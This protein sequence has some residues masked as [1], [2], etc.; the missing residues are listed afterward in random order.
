MSAWTVD[1]RA[2]LVG[3]GEGKPDP[4]SVDITNSVQKE[5]I[6]HAL[7]MNIG[8]VIGA[9]L[10]G[11][12]KVPN[13]LLSHAVSAIKNNNPIAGSF[14]VAPT[15]VAVHTALG[16]LPNIAGFTG[17]DRDKV[18]S[19]ALSTPRGFNSVIE[20]AMLY[21]TSTFL[22]TDGLGDLPKA[23]KLM[24]A[25]ALI[26][27]P[28]TIIRSYKEA[29]SVAT[30]SAGLSEVRQLDRRSIDMYAK[31]LYDAVHPY[32]TMLVMRFYARDDLTFVVPREKS[33]PKETPP[34]DLWSVV[35]IIVDTLV[36]RA[37]E[38]AEKGN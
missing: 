3:A 31:L 17:L 35:S 33:P 15:I 24:A 1:Q 2:A 10:H 38:I 22:E 8:L 18:V 19:W 29:L 7:S 27:I 28:E 6:G 34:A 9:F 26:R 5:R 37:V 4:K 32:L 11:T 23:E 16:A 30:F 12:S 13:D 36:N 25:A 21:P 20:E 14:V